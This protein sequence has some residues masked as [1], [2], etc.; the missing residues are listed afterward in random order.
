MGKNQ[1]PG[2]GINIPDPLKILHFLCRSLRQMQEELKMVREVYIT[3]ARAN[4]RRGV[5]DQ[6]E[7]SSWFYTGP[8]AGKHA[9]VADTDGCQL[10]GKLG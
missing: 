1:D 5:L 2:S 7:R 6:Q 10:Q 3:E 4:L 9:P 8:I